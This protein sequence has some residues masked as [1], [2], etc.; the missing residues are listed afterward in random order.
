MSSDLV[1]V[2]ERIIALCPL[3]SLP[4]PLTTAGAVKAESDCSFSDDSLPVFVVRRGPGIRHV[5]NDA[6][7][8]QSTREYLLK[9]FVQ[10]IEDDTK[11][12]SDEAARELAADCILPVLVFFGGRRALELDDNG[13]VE[14]Q[15]IVQDSGD[16]RPFTTNS[17]KFSGVLFRMQVTTR[18]YVAGE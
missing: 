10:R 17:R 16:T 13:M 5:W 18:H 1:I 14:S 3:I 7:M 4:A 2:Q 12:G 11:P 6:D 15:T 8:L 9:L